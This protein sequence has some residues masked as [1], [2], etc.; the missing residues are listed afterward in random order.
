M[1]AGENFPMDDSYARFFS[2]ICCHKYQYGTHDMH[3]AESDL[4]NVRCGR[5]DWRTCL[6]EPFPVLARTEQDFL[7]RE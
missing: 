4:S 2:A 3:A 5:L 7:L 1:A 6:G